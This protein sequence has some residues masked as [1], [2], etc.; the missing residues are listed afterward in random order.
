MTIDILEKTEQP[1][2]SRT[3]ILAEVTFEGPVPSRKDLKVKLASKLNLKD[4]F[5]VIRRIDTAYGFRKAK[6]FASVYKDEK[7]LKMLSSKYLLKRGLLKE[8][9]KEEPKE[10]AKEAPKEE[11]PKEKD[12]E[13]AKE[14]S[15]NP[16]KK[17]APKEEVKEEKK[18]E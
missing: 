1:L 6:V 12:N 5:I 10:E 8:K 16:D 18:T 15:P 17:E 14:E 7:A 9:K 4:E 2:L 11:K 13:Q 3:D